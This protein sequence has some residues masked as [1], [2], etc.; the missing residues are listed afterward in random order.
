MSTRTTLE[1]TA[2]VGLVA[3]GHLALAT[4]DLEE[5]LQSA[6][7][8]GQDLLSAMASTASVAAMVEAWETPPL[9]SPPPL[10]AMTAPEVSPSQMAPQPETP[11]APAMLPAV[12][13][14]HTS[15]D[16][17]PLPV[18]SPPPATVSGAAAP[19][20]Q[21]SPKQPENEAAPPRVA[22]VAP[23]DSPVPPP[24]P[25]PMPPDKPMAPQAKPSPPAVK[26]KPKDVP[27]AKTRSAA[28]S[29]SAG[30]TAQGSGG[31]TAKGNNGSDQI[32]SVSDSKRVSLLKKWGAQVRARVAHRAPEGAG[33]GVAHVRISVAA[34][35]QVL[36]AK[37]VKS[38]GNARLDK[39][40]LVAVKKAG[41]MPKAPAKLQV[42]SQVFTIPLRSR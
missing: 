11:V 19:A 38:S 16:A 8:A 17:L 12:S 18:A 23:D 2:F 40:A 30:R 9:D 32:A 15:A 25:T 26:P 3:V 29:A 35:G 10:P 4:P 34:N 28:S 27:V 22:S 31:E 24:I 1:L 13:M 7:S 36:E 21:D 33:K 42:K 37:L 20:L 5:G 6:G 39:L 41:R 14:Q